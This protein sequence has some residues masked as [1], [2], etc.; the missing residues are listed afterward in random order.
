VTPTVIATPPTSSS[1]SSTVK[2]ST[3]RCSRIVHHAL[4]VKGWIASPPSAGSARP[5]ACVDC[6]EASRPAGGRLGLH[7]H[8]LRDRQVR[9]PLDADGPSTTVVVACR[10]Y[11]CVACGAILTVVPRG[12][13]PRRHYGHAAIAMALALWAIVGEPVGGIRRRVCAWRH[14]HEPGTRWPTLRRWAR[15]ARDAGGDGGVTLEAAAAR[16]AQI[17][18]GRAPPE[19]RHGPRWAQ[20][21]AGGSA[22]P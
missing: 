12:V 13:A 21:F 19:A 3:R 5:A 18:I 9:G 4:D 15:A 20:A 2:K 10:R 7:G 22:M 6:G 8:G 1:R 16:A 11:L 14:S 17:A